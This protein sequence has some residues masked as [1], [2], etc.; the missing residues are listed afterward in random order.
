MMMMGGRK[1]PKVG[2]IDVGIKNCSYGG[3]VSYYYRQK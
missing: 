3:I 2:N 1:E